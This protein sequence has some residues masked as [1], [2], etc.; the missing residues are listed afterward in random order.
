VLAFLRSIP[1]SRQALLLALG[2]ITL[3]AYWPVLGRMARR[4]CDDPQYSHGFLVPVFAV[5]LLWMRR[6]QLT[7]HPPKSALGPGVAVLLAAIG[8]RCLGAYFYV[9]WLDDMSLLVCLTGVFVL[10]GGGP[11]LRWSWP[12]LAFLLFMVPLPYSLETALAFPLRRVATSTSTYALQTVGFPALADG[13]DILIGDKPPLQVAPACSG[14]GMLLVF[15]ALST[16][17]LL[18][19]QRPLLDKIVILISAIPIAILANIVRITVTAVLY[20]FASTAAGK[21]FFHNW[22]GYCMMLVGLA[23]LWVEVKIL[24]RLLVVQDLRR[25]LALDFAKGAGDRGRP[26]LQGLKSPTQ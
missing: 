13:T 12:A 23:F 11:A 8:L 19:I 22:A 3:W 16:A 7:T 15:F 6:Q 9:G 24:D 26:R 20:E 4:W 18:V 2:G 10:L 21:E 17:I 5:A 14:L 25:P 1:P